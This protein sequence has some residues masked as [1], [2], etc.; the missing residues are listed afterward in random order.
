[1]NVYM[2]KK[3]SDSLNYEIH[4]IKEMKTIEISFFFSNCEIIRF[5]GQILIR[6]ENIFDSV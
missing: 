3:N 1:M 4:V 6:L 5:H 2:Q